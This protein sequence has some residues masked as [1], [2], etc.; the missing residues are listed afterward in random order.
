MDTKTDIKQLQHL[1]GGDWVD[2][3]DGATFDVLNPL[4]DSTYAKAAK[5]SGDD[6]GKAVAAAKAAFSAYRETL[7]KERERWL[8]RVA[9]IMEE[10]KS[11]L[12]LDCLIDEIGSP[13][14]EGDVR[15]RQ[16]A[17]H[18]PRRRW[19][20]P[21]CARRNHSIGCARQVLHVNPRTS[22]CRGR[23]YSV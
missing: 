21:Q 4:D 15:V 22:G 8:L 3:K 13:S 14:P 1:I 6:M 11:E 2:A 12:L 7:P 18:G 17:D 5:G 20:L 16:G 10:R 19:A 9:E 23:Y